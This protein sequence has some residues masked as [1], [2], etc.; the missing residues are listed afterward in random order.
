MH[1]MIITVIISTTY[2]RCG[3][4]INLAIGF[5]IDVLSWIVLFGCQLSIRIHPRP[6]PAL[7]CLHT[8]KA[9]KKFLENLSIILDPAPRPSE[10]RS[11]TPHTT[12]AL[13]VPAHDMADLTA[14]YFET[15]PVTRYYVT[16]AL[17]ITAGC[18][19]DM[20]TP[21]QLYF[22]WPAIMAGEVWRFFT[23]FLF[24]GNKFGTQR[25]SG[26]GPLTC[27]TFFFIHV[28]YRCVCSP[29]M[30]FVSVTLASVAQ[31]S[32]SFFTCSFYVDTAVHWRSRRSAAKPTTSFGSSFSG[33][34]V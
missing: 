34:C 3:P 11:L 13:T 22:S 14:W 1:V 18:V 32:I 4:Y 17:L 16:L 23:T 6:L 26:T 30:V 2:S 29:L 27:I 25:S 15:P 28:V 21:F 12:A 8:H 10:V 5:A 7:P 19:F 24:F 9:K 31:I 33:H 20:I